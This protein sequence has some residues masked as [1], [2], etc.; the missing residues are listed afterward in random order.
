[1]QLSIQQT[2]STDHR[3]ELVL[4]VKPAD[5]DIPTVLMV[6]VCQH[7]HCSEMKMTKVHIL[8]FKRVQYMIVDITSQLHSVHP[9]NMLQVTLAG[10]H[11][12]NGVDESSPHN[13]LLVYD[14]A[15]PHLS[16]ITLPPNLKNVTVAK[17]RV[18]RS[19]NVAPNF[20]CHLEE[21]SISIQDLKW[22]NWILRP[23]SVNANLCRGQCNPKDKKKMYQFSNNA[24]MR[25]TFNEVHVDANEDAWLVPQ[26]CCVPL[27]VNPVSIIFINNKGNL[28]MTS[29]ADMTA[30]ECGCI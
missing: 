28:A 19:V 27:I 9:S 20:G 1:M 10:P 24:Y 25:Y 18:H 5:V 11:L 23:E 26:P 30:Q 4:V 12:K 6:Q 2:K 3:Y 15:R 16:L 7:R 22:Q 13:M 21:W 14:K 29:M 17:P 8:P